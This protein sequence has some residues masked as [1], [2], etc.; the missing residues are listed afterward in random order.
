MNNG[1]KL[2]LK[3]QEEIAKRL[4]D[5]R[6]SAGYTQ[7]DIAEKIKTTTKTYREWEVGKY[8]KDDT[9]YY[10]AIGYDNLL[11]LSE[12][13]HVSTDYLLC[14]SNCTSVDNHYISQ[15]TGLSETSINI[16]KEKKCDILDAFIQSSA[17]K[18]IAEYT[19][20][21]LE[22]NFRNFRDYA[23][24]AVDLEESASKTKEISNS[25][26][27]R[28]AKTQDRYLDRIEHCA[29]SIEN[30]GYRCSLSFG[31]FLDAA[32]NELATKYEYDTYIQLLKKTCS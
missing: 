3:T 13:Y 11:L 12:V 22:N 15:K 29:N 17:Y 24:I 4:K 16:I 26:L 2:P 27:E 23:K 18:E 30:F 28:L 32:K 25:E 7:D 9:F 20:Y 19:L 6:I 10:P 1:N 21:F 8:G 31:K 14:N 5:L